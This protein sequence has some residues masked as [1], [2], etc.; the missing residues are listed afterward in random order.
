MP[1]KIWKTMEAWKTTK[2]KWN[3]RGNWKWDIER[4]SIEWTISIKSG[5]FDELDQYREDFG[6]QEKLMQIMK[7]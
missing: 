5:Y 1:H 4:T 2:K 3:L 6:T 7:F